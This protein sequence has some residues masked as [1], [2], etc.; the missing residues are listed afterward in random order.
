[1]AAPRPLRILEVVVRFSPYIGGVENTVLDLNRRLVARGH[2]VRVVCADEPPGSPDRVEGI[3]VVRLPYRR[4][5]VGNTNVC[6]GLPA[7]LRRERPDLIHGHMPTAL[8][9]DA[10]ASAAEALG[11][12]F[13][14]TYH[15][16]LIGDGL[17]GVL[18]GI[19]NRFI[20][21]RLLARADRVITINPSYA[22]KSPHLSADDPKISCVPW[23]VDEAVFHPPP[24]GG[25]P[26]DAPELVLGFLS[27]LDAHH[28][29]KGLEVLFR[30]AAELRRAGVPLRLKIGGTGEKQGSYRKMAAELGVGDRT[31]FLGF[32]PGPDLPAFYGSC[33]A[34]V[35][36]STDGRREGFGLVLLEAMACAR[37]V[38]STP[39]VGMS[40][41]I[42][43]YE[44]GLLATPGDPAALAAAIRRLHEDRASL[45]VFGANGRRLVEERYTW[46]RVTDAY[47]ALYQ[48]A[49]RSKGAAV[50]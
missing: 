16:D 34:F 30:A 27:L 10:A 6:P 21:P 2:Q 13:V 37:P 36:P 4:F 20:L 38:L 22:T 40:G 17:K 28:R 1:M 29:Y 23:G 24:D 45:A 31:E 11:V 50:I 8:F 32:I 3:D 44:A 25:P 48:E 15:N 35:L 46:T 26:A 49:V 33:H 9:A 39:I 41:D 19:Y 47:E 14:L 43:K 7:A 12:P 5:K 42:Q 18:G